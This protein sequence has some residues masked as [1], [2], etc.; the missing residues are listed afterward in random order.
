MNTIWIHLF[1]VT[2]LL[3]KNVVVDA[4][5]SN[6][7][8][9]QFTRTQK[10]S[11]HKNGIDQRFQSEKGDMRAE[12]PISKEI[13]RRH[14][15]RFAITASIGWTA[16][17]GN[18]LPSNAACLSG[19]TRESCI[20]TYKL[21]LDDQVAS[22]IDTPEHLEKFAPDLKWVPPVEYPKDFQ[23]ARK[24]LLELQTQVSNLKDVVL[25]GELVS[26]GTSLLSMVPRIT[27]AGRVAVNSM[28]NT[29]KKDEFSMKV[30][31]AEVAH[32]ELLMALGSCDIIIGQGIRG[33]TGSITMTQIQVIKDLT[34]AND[35]FAEL[36][37]AVPERI[38]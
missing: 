26:A 33:D 29:P 25:Q 23:M 19:D 14:W 31:R 8:R 28:K 30:Y 37:N 10:E 15:L 4:F 9:I 24:E 6:E 35:R 17:S 18:D 3:L 7:R 12:S 32:Y 38:S 13:D 2:G 1:F 36:M 11:I 16:L 5:G 20:G 21:P 34:D 22:F 27:V